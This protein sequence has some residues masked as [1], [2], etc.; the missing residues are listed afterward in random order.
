[1]DGFSSTVDMC[2]CSMLTLIIIIA[3]SWRRTNHCCAC[4]CFDGRHF[5]LDVFVQL[6]HQCPGLRE[7]DSGVLSVGQEFLQVV[8]CS[9]RQ[10]PDS[11]C[12]MGQHINTH[13]GHHAALTQV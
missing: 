10:T 9:R 7:S 1:M 12:S 4:I 8:D 11:I 6:W 5:C 2:A 3:V 13:T